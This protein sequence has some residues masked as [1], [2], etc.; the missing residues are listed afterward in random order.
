MMVP[1]RP[2][3]APRPA[4]PPVVTG[5]PPVR[6]AGPPVTIDLPASPA[7]ARTA[8]QSLA[9]SLSRPAGIEA[10]T[11]TAGFTAVASQYYE[12]T[13]LP[14]A[15]ALAKLASLLP[16]YTFT[17]DRGVMHMQPRALVNDPS[18]WLNMKVD[19]FDQHFDNARDAMNAVAAIRARPAPG[20]PP[21]PAPVTIAPPSTGM[22]GGI[23]SGIPGGIVGGF[24]DTLGPRLV[25]SITISMTNVTVREILDEMVRQHGSLTWT[26]DHRAST[27]QIAL[28]FSSQGWMIGTSVR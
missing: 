24:P 12:L 26:L 15:D 21:A 28:S 7:R 8:F 6:P 25:T 4:E 9:R 18:N 16:E 27:A 3:A 14:A 5:P 13:G 2:A 22:V 19:K 17:E 20:F 11:D 10:V 23:S 1:V